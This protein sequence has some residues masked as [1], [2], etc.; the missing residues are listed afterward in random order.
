MLPSI[1]PGQF[2]DGLLVAQV[3]CLDTNSSDES[4][5]LSAEARLFELHHGHGQVLGLIESRS[6]SVDIDHELLPSRSDRRVETFPCL[7]TSAETN[8]PNPTRFEEETVATNHHTLAGRT[9]RE[10]RE[11]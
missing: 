1:R 6:A 3:R 2:L 8:G 9:A 4:G 5:N 10:R 7:E 11:N